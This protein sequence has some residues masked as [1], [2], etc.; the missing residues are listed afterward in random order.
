MM[1]KVPTPSS[2]VPQAQ[3]P[4][5]MGNA[6]VF[7]PGTGNF[8]SF[9]WIIRTPFSQR[10]AEN[11]RRCSNALPPQPVGIPRA[12]VLP[13]GARET[14]IA[15]FAKEVANASRIYQKTVKNGCMKCGKDAMLSK[16]KAT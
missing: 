3:G 1:V 4:S 12:A 6:L 2:V 14:M 7:F 16:E 11:A 5:S 9:Q 8:R 15:G 13:H 10:P